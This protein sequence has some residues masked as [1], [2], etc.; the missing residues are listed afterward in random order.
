MV[1]LFL[2]GQRIFNSRNGGVMENENTKVSVALGYTLNLGNFQSLRFDFG[3]VDS[4]RNGETPD[5]AF[6]RIY[7][8][9]E[10][11][12]TEKVKEAEAESDSK[13]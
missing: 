5:Q 9:V 10:D 3:V 12:L 1:D 4:K 6:E 7:K 11:K 2:F 8:F 13:E